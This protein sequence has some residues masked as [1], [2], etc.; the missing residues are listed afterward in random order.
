MA[1]SSIEDFSQELQLPRVMSESD[2]SSVINAIN[3]SALWTSFGHV[4]QD[5]I[6]AQASFV[7][8][9]FRHLNRAYNYAAHE[10]ALFARRNGSHQ[11]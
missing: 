6:Q 2:A 10:L 8:C 1:R 7:F 5:I 11:R 9:S 3:D 4:I